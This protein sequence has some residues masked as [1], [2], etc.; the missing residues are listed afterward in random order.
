VVAAHPGSNK[1]TIRRNNRKRQESYQW[2]EFEED[3]IPL[4]GNR[5]GLADNIIFLPDKHPLLQFTPN[6]NQIKS[7]SLDVRISLYPSASPV[8]APICGASSP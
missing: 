2:F 6:A 3:L 4:V 7:L 5:H 1:L 8:L